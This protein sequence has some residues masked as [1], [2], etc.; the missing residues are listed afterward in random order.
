MGWGL[1]NTQTVGSETPCDACAGSSPLLG[2]TKDVDTLTYVHIFPEQSFICTCKHQ[3]WCLGCGRNSR[4]LGVALLL[5][6]F[7]LHSLN[8]AHVWWLV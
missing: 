3:S 2:T 5:P 4:G 6:H 7:C 8:G 1:L